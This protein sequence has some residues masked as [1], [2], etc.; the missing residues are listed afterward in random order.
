MATFYDKA[1]A[2]LS[3]P[4]CYA[5]PV[6]RQIWTDRRGCLNFGRCF[7][8]SLIDSG[9]NMKFI[10]FGAVDYPEAEVENVLEKR[11][12]FGPRLKMLIDVF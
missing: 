6:E 3:G 10:S 8:A 5:D 2:N 9:T 4:P 7:L 11:K 1:R 12:D